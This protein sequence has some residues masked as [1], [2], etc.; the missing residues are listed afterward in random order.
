MEKSFGIRRPCCDNYELDVAVK[1][2]FFSHVAAG[3]KYVCRRLQIS[4]WCQLLDFHQELLGAL[5]WLKM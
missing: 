3:A 2:K 5:Q 1:C 4:T